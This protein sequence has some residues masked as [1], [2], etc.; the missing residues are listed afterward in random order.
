MSDQ[1]TSE[2]GP[3]QQLQA[4]PAGALLQRFSLEILFP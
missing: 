3:A 4:T 2:N 1:F